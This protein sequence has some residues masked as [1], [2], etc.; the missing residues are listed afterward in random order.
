MVELT[1]ISVIECPEM[2]FL[3]Y[4]SVKKIYR[5]V[6]YIVEVFVNGELA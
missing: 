1:N 2:P 6:I 3:V 5:Q 4:L